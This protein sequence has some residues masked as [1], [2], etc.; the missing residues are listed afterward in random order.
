MKKW[1]TACC[2]FM[3][4]SLFAQEKEIFYVFDSLWKPT[5][6]KNARY[7]ACVT[8]ENGNYQA[9]FYNYFGPMLWV[10]SYSDKEFKIR[11]GKCRY[12]DQEGNLD[13]S[14]QY[15]NGKK[16]G[17]F[18]KSKRIKEDSFILATEYVY[19]ADSLLKVI[20]RSKDTLPKTDTAN[21]KESEY[22]GSLRA[23]SRF[24]GKHLS[25]P[26]R[27]QNSQ[28]AGEVRVSFSVDE[29]GKVGDIYIS[30]SREYSLDTESIKMIE[31][32]GRWNPASKSGVYVKSYKR[33]P[34]IFRLDR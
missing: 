19:R 17:S 30:K 14:G 13:S 21:E 18:Y 1:L 6:V 34:I 26:E 9:K 10:E 4:I 2:T 16:E 24:L 5:E 33:Q 3:T 8:S 20:D 28:I 7:V 11:H 15:V 29:Q 23:W 27:A 25:Y 31:I 12:Y 22:P 32:S